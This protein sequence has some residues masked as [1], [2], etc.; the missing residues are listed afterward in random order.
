MK[1]RRAYLA[2]LL[3]AMICAACGGGQGPNPSPTNYG[4]AETARVS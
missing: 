4:S 2:T 1:M 3:I